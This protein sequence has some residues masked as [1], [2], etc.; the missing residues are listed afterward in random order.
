MAKL[1]K[2]KLYYRHDHPDG[3]R[4]GAGQPQ[5]DSRHGW[6]ADPAKIKPAPAKHYECTTFDAY[7][8]L[9][10]SERAAAKAA[11]GERDAALAGRDEA[12]AR[13]VDLVNALAGVPKPA[14]QEA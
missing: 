4:F 1:A 3:Y 2:D 14:E 9:L 6:V 5:P 11:R 13:Y 7:E 10:A 12:R 8:G